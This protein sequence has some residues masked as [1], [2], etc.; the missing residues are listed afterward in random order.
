MPSGAVSYEVVYSS[1]GIERSVEVSVSNA[2]ITGLQPGTAHRFQVIA[3]G[4]R[5]QKSKRSAEVEAATSKS[6]K[7]WS[8][9][10]WI[11]Y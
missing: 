2:E 7:F 4:D 11:E 8:K 3:V 10:I 6:P 9:S 5:T 1:L